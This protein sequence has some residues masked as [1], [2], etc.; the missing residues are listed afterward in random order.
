MQRSDWQRVAKVG[1][2][3]GEVV[4]ALIK[5]A[6]GRSDTAHLLAELGDVFLAALAAADQLGVTPSAIISARWAD[7]SQRSQRAESLT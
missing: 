5:R 3:G 7:V 6:E 4:G 2:E 1:E